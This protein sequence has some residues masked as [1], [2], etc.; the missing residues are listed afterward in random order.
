[1]AKSAI[2]RAPVTI[3]RLV[4]DRRLASP[5]YGTITAGKH[6]KIVSA[7]SVVSVPPIGVILRAT[8][9]DVNDRQSSWATK[10]PAPIHPPGVPSALGSLHS[11]SNGTSKCVVAMNATGKRQNRGD[12]AGIGCSRVDIKPPK[13]SS[14]LWVEQPQS[15]SHR[16]I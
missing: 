10:R 4:N 7:T 15:T 9:T 14:D 3:R 1:M 2:C 11:I 16:N 8:L 5:R 13:T 12:G 6:M